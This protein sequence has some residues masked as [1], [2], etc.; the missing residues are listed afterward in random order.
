[1]SIDGGDWRAFPEGISLEDLE[2]R[3]ER[4][5]ENGDVIAAGNWLFHAKRRGAQGV[6]EKLQRLVP[7]LESASAG[8]D[9]EAS[10][11]LAATLLERGKDLE[12]AILL[13][14]AAADSGSPIAMRELGYML[15]SGIGA[16]KDLGRANLLYGRAA[17]LGDGYA[18]FN[19]AVNHYHGIGVGRSFRNYSKYLQLAAD[20]GIPEACAVLGDQLA[21]QHREDEALCYYL[22]AARSGHAPAMFA[23]ALMYRDGNGVEADSVQAVRWFL[24]MLDRGNGDGVHEILSMLHGM[25]R[26]QI[27]EAGLL[28]GRLD[29]ARSFLA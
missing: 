17:E 18:A 4:A 15:S 11:L 27:L 29:D 22:R 20:R 7:Y 3:A 23:A 24:S 13:F 6:R 9:V 5:A 16:P 28:S 25:T 1:M 26:E 8:G 2:N 12:R 21:D 10:A 14:S 19:L